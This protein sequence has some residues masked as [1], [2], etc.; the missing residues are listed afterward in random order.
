MTLI[1]LLLPLACKLDEHIRM[2]PGG[3]F[4][5]EHVGESPFE[6]YWILRLLPGM[7]FFAYLFL[8]IICMLFFSQAEFSIQTFSLTGE[9]YNPFQWIT[10]GTYFLI[11]AS[12]IFLIFDSFLSAGFIGAVPHMIA[13]LGANIISFVLAFVIIITLL[14]AVP[15][16]I[17]VILVVL[18]IAGLFTASYRVIYIYV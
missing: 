3:Q 10:Q 11:L 16:A 12:T 8:R 6:D 17:G 13:V 1:V 18:V 15:V 7:V 9:G 2:L 4:L 5:E 14:Q